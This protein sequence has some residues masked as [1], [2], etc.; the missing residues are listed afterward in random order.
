[1]SLTMRRRTELVSAI[2][3]SLLMRWVV[4]PQRFRQEPPPSAGRYEATIPSMHP[5]NSIGLLGCYSSRRVRNLRQCFPYWRMAV[6]FWAIA[7]V[8]SFALTC[9]AAEWSPFA[10][11][12]S[13]VISVRVAVDATACGP[14]ALGGHNHRHV[15]R[16]ADGK[17]LC[18]R[19]PNDAH[20]RYR[21][22]ADSPDARCRPAGRCPAAER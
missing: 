19:S 3:V 18:Q 2:G 20:H 7:L 22:P 10:S 16:R 8:T 4:Q 21:R 6:Y 15:Q 1:M 17:P 11:P 14:R 13:N 5:L 12:A 9:H